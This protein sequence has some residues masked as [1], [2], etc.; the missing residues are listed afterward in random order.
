M[1]K[2]FALVA[3]CCASLLAAAACT[4]S[5]VANDTAT[6]DVAIAKDV[7]DVIAFKASPSVAAGEILAADAAVLASDIAQLKTDLGS[8]QVP[9][10]VA[11]ALDKASQ[12][13]AELKAPA[14]TGSA[15]LL[16]DARAVQRAAKAADGA[17]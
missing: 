7:A 6:L 10:K 9:A 8:A 12:L 1:I 13:A 17:A 16:A 5:A 15:K 4:P 14:A 3:V 2:R 11:T